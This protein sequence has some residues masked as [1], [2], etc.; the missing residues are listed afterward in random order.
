MYDFSWDICYI[1]QGDNKYILVKNINIKMRITFLRLVEQNV[2]LKRNIFFKLLIIIWVHIY[3]NFKK[4]K[5]LYF[6]DY[7]DSIN[8][9]ILYN[10]KI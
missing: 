3:Y 8:F 5:N 1:S 6:C 4:Y 9:S 7:V 2:K 10:Y